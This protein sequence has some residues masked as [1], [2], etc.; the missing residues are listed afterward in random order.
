M[1]DVVGPSTGEST[2]CDQLHSV[3]TITVDNSIRRQ[4]LK[5]RHIVAT[6]HTQRVHPHVMYQDSVVNKTRQITLPTS[7]LSYD[8]LEDAAKSFGHSKKGRE[9]WAQ[10]LQYGLNTVDE[11]DLTYLFM[12]RA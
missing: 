11:P 2:I 8:S 12:F 3:Y 5:H 1:G 7:K 9:A 6:M 10:A 4:E